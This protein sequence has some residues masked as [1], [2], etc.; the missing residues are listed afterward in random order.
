MGCLAEKGHGIRVWRAFKKAPHPEAAHGVI[1]RHLPQGLAKMLTKVELEAIRLRLLNLPEAPKH[2]HLKL[3]DWLGALLVFFWVLIV[4]FPV[5]MPFLF[6][7]D[8]TV[9]MR[10]SN[11]VGLV[12]LFITGYAFGRCAEFW[13]WL[14]G[15]A[16]MLIGF[17]LVAL[18]I[19]LGG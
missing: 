11:G 13:P 16:M 15:L 3:E 18:T 12:L 6:I 7:G 2:P 4:T 17:C 19:H 5:A 14:T 1:S 8:V 10:V 9:A